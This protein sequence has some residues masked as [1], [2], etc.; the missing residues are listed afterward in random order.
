MTKK[1]Y[2]GAFEVVLWATGVVI[3]VAATK[4]LKKH[5]K[6]SKIS[7]SENVLKL[8]RY[9]ANG[10]LKHPYLT[11][12]YFQDLLKGSKIN[13]SDQKYHAANFT[14]LAC[15]ISSLCLENEK[16]SGKGTNSMTYIDQIKNYFD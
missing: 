5:T 15:A 3:W 9:F 6:D 8:R 10:C 11:A 12:E 2:L 13:C 7:E 16:E 1:I 4:R 14:D